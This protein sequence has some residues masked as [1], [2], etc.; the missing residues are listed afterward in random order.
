MSQD[1]SETTKLS[2]SQVEDKL[3]TLK[4]KQQTKQSKRDQLNKELDQ[5]EHQI[6][7]YEEILCYIKEFI[8]SRPAHPACSSIYRSCIQ[9]AR[10]SIIC[11][12]KIFDTKNCLILQKEF[13]EKKLTSK[14]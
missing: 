4:E 14:I 12:F 6:E 11:F 8:G 10:A 9:Q 2:Q 5:I 3:D 13:F 1:I 7:S